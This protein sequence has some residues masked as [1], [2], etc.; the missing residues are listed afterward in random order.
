MGRKAK[1]SV[2]PRGDKWE[3]SLPERRGSTVRVYASFDTEAEG[4]AW[5]RVG[6]EVLAAGGSPSAPDGP[7]ATKDSPAPATQRTGPDFVAMAED[8]VDLHYVSNHRAGAERE[9][10]VRDYLRLHLVPAF[11]GPMPLIGEAAAGQAGDTA[12]I[13]WVRTRAGYPARSSTSSL[14]PLAKPLKASYV[15]ELLWALRSVQEH[16]RSQGHPVQDTIGSVVAMTPKGGGRKR[17]GRLASFEVCRDIAGQMHA[18]HQLAFWIMRVLGLRISEVYGLTVGNVVDLGGYGLLQVEGQGGRRF[19][20]RTDDEVVEASDRKETGKT[21]AAYR[22]IVIPQPLME[23]IRVV[24]DAYYGDDD[25]GPGPGARLIPAIRST[26]GGQA[27]FRNALKVAAAA[28]GVDGSDDSFTAHDFRKSLS[29]DLGWRDDISELLQRRILGHRAGDDVYATTYLLDSREVADLM[30]AATAI[31]EAIAASIGT[32][33]IPTAKRPAFGAATDDARRR[34][35]D[36]VLTEAGIHVDTAD[37]RLDSAGVAAMLGCSGTTARTLMQKKAVS[38]VKVDGAW[39][40]QPGD[41]EAYRDRWGA[42]E[43]LG[44]IAEAAGASYHQAYTVM[45]RLGIEPASAPGSGLLL[46]NGAQAAAITAEF[47]RIGALHQRAMRVADVCA[48]LGAATSTVHRWIADGTL[49]LDPESDGSR[50]KFIS[51]SSVKAEFARRGE[52]TVPAVPVAEFT[53]ASGLDVAA[54]R[55][56]VSRGILAWAGR[57]RSQRLT[58]A[59]VEA[60]ATGYRPDLIGAW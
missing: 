7:R 55:V 39:F 23:L 58:R 60:W 27:G 16:A 42:Y 28:L 15:T 53:G 33:L 4:W 5:C 13:D 56:L 59:S 32:L 21:G 46:L 24:I 8:W 37:G 49:V 2:R 9:M 47:A 3:A 14:K 51:R 48:A 12:V 22:L 18:V 38:A 35:I 57:P 40:A 20:H 45:Q 54:V 43:M 19:L 11:G 26:G 25:G 44:D 30:P 10:Q 29:T 1:G 36:A 50:A 41:V 52:P 34:R 6:A 31:E 17:R